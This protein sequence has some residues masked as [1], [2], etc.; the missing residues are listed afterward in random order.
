MSP[1]T[2]YHVLNRCV[3]GSFLCGE[4]SYSHKNYDHRRQWLINRIKLLAQ[5]FS[6]DIAAYAIMSNDYQ[7]VLHVDQS[8]AKNWL[9]EEMITRRHVLFGG[10]HYSDRLFEK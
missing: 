5:V 8:R 9:L 1:T 4:D 7:L 6:I 2:F 3:R 10:H